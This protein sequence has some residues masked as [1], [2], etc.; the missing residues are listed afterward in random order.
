MATPLRFARSLMPMLVTIALI[1]ACS[2]DPLSPFQPEIGNVADNFQLQATN[3]TG[4][5]ATRIYSWSNSGTRAT[6]NHSTVTSAGS[7]RFIVRD[8]AGT[9]VY[10]KALAPSLNESTI[11]GTAGVW[12]IQLQL[13]TYS[14]TLNVRSQKL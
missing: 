13:T 8:A 7:A 12:T 11:A 5:T 10:D 2:K 6:I 3:V 9:V 1:G 4:V 14:G